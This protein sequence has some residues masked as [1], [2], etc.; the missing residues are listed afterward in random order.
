MSKVTE[1]VDVREVPA[2]VKKKKGKI[3]LKV[4]L[5]VLIIIVAV[6]AVSAVVNVIL[7]N[8]LIKYAESF[9]TV[10]YENQLAPEKDASGDRY[11]TT[12]D[13]F[14]V[15]QLTDVHLGSGW[16]SYK[17]DKQAINAVAAM[18]TREKPDLVVVTGDIA[19]PVFF[20][21]GTANNKNAAKVFTALM[22]KLGVYWTVMF[23][24]H[25]T[26]AYA[27]YSRED[28]ADFYENSGFAHSV[29]TAGPEDVD[30]SCNNVIKIKNSKG[31]ITS[32]VISFD[33]H[34]YVDD[35]PFGILAHY[36]NIHE[37]QVAWYEQQINRL[38]GENADVISGLNG[39][40]KSFK[41]VQSFAFFHI[42]LVE[43]SDAWDEFQANGYKDT[44]NVK[45][46]EGFKGEN[47][48][49]GSGEDGLFEKML[50]LGSTKAVLCGHDHVNNTSLNYKGIDLIYG[51]SVDCLAYMGINKLGSQ[52]GCTIL[53]CKPDAT[54]EV[55][56]YNY[57]SDRYVLD[58]FEREDVTMQ[59]EGME[60]E[61]L[62]ESG[63]GRPVFA[64]EK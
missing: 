3:L 6:I 25:D 55:N 50:E 60:F 2:K 42:P 30:G 61:D 27:Y 19:Y 28:I 26:E 23:G 24:N 31:I 51:N 11:F 13:D 22:E 64:E 7:T 14:N 57:Y 29:F 49:C 10:V 43:Y 46:I 63:K 8:N 59:Y 53:T 48:C 1:N 39:K 16:M 45:Y 41:N 40:Y 35:D 56:K 62:S 5:S 38:N 18:I 20:Q 33:S 44:E 15:M 34:S 54:Y 21:A 37:N 32:A 4:L 17:K 47:E 12:D 58:G 52:R 36:D 9:D